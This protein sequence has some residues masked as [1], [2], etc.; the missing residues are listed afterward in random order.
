MICFQL[1]IVAG[2]LR[3]N[4]DFDL[5]DF[6]EPIVRAA[7]KLTPDNPLESPRCPACGLVTG[8]ESSCTNRP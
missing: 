1:G 2:K 5:S 6:V 7:R 3:A 4:E 8:H